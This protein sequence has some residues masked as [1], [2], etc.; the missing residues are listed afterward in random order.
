M[1][2]LLDKFVNRTKRRGLGEHQVIRLDTIGPVL[3]S[4]GAVS[5]LFGHGVHRPLRN[6]R[7]AGIAWMFIRT[8]YA[9]S[10]DRQH[11]L[12]VVTGTD[13]QNAPAFI[14]HSISC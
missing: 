11:L 5:A 10:K 2:S 13:M 4:S 8:R 3:E 9:D 12:T 6:F 1:V 7:R 14:S